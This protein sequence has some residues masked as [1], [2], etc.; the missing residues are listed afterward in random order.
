MLPRG[1]VAAD[2]EAGL[3]VGETLPVRPGGGGGWTA[4]GGAGLDALLILGSQQTG[5]AM[6]AFDDTFGVRL[7][8]KGKRMPDRGPG[9]QQVPLYC[10]KSLLR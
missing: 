5:S 7:S 6:H 3:A 9:T 1:V 4:P 8:V 2:G 10:E